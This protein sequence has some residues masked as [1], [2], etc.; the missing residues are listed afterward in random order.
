MMQA[1]LD[2]V[3]GGVVVGPAGVLL[4]PHGERHA[5]LELLLEDVAPGQSRCG[6]VSSASALAAAAVGSS[7]TALSHLVLS[8]TISRVFSAGL[9]LVEE[10]DDRRVVEGAVREDLL[11]E[12]Q[13]LRMESVR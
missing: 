11:E 5:A 2:V 12:L 6:V 7:S 8:R 9:A 10:E 1:R 4:V 13:R 3:D